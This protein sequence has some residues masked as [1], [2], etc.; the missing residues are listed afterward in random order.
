MERE[1]IVAEDNMD[2][3]RT[4]NHRRRREAKAQGMAGK[5]KVDN[6]NKINKL[7]AHCPSQQ[8]MRNQSPAVNHDIGANIVRRRTSRG[9]MTS[10]SVNT[11]AEN[12]GDHS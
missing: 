7:Y 8:V 9:T 11:D 1:T 6:N 2:S 5:E 4:H 3:H 12:G 10:V